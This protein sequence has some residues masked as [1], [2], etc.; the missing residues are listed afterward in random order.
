MEKFVARDRYAKETWA[1]RH[2]NTVFF[3]RLNT[4]YLRQPI[5]SLIRR[6]NTKQTLQL[7]FDHPR[8][9]GVIDKVMAFGSCSSRFDTCD[10]LM[11]LSSQASGGR[12]R[13]N[14]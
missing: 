7:R 3:A 4:I 10:I 13:K 8:G 14:A 1:L 11:L 9:H 6:V 12:K 2:V 5:Q